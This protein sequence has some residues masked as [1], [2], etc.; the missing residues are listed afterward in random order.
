MKQWKGAVERCSGKMQRN[1]G[2]GNTY[3]VDDG[4]HG[5]GV[6]NVLSRH[7]EPYYS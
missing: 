2:K 6:K 3:M 1:N 7:L 5:A 4:W